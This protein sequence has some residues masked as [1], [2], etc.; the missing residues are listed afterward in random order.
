MR[1]RNFKFHRADLKS[2]VARCRDFRS[3]TYGLMG[4]DEVLM[5]RNPRPVEDIAE[6]P[7]GS[8]RRR[9]E[10]KSWKSNA[11][12]ETARVLICCRS[13]GSA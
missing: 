6:C 2:H 1:A 10:S 7:D 4:S 13:V 11:V 9:G 8:R 12:L 3:T 5:E